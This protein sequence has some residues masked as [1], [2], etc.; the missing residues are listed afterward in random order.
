MFNGL[1]EIYSIG[2]EYLFL[3]ITIIFHLVGWLLAKVGYLLTNGWFW[4]AL[5]IIS[6]QSQANR[7]NSRER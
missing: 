6:V 4:V 2:F 3:A 5:I 7:F 1:M